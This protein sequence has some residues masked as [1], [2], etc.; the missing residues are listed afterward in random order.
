MLSHNVSSWIETAAGGRVISVAVLQLS[1]SFTR[2]ASPVLNENRPDHPEPD[3][4]G[5]EKADHPEA[6]LI[7]HQ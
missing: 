4:A 7:R 2:A 5:D 3:D 6:A 1:L